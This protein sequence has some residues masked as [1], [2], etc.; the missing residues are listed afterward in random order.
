MGGSCLSQR[1]NS[2]NGLWVGPEG[3]MLGVKNDQFLWTDGR[4][5][6]M[7]GLMNVTEDHVVANIDGSNRQISYD[8]KVQGNEL[9]TKDAGGVIRNY[10]RYSVGPVLY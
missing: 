1:V 6:H 5:Q 3:E 9:L 2:L 10:R 7:S 8:Y 4:D